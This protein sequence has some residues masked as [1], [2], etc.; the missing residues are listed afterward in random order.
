MGENK[1]HFQY[2]TDLNIAG[3]HAYYICS[4]KHVH[5]KYSIILNASSTDHMLS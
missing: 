2:P 1:S 4:Y 5:L 3:T